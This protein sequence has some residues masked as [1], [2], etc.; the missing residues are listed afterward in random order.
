MISQLSKYTRKY[1][2]TCT[3][4]VVTSRQSQAHSAGVRVVKGLV[5]DVDVTDTAAVAAWAGAAAV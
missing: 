3:L 4:H 1:Q 2:I 5:L